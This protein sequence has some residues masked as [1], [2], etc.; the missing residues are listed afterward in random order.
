M[1][2]IVTKSAGFCFGVRKT[3]EIAVKESEKGEKIFTLGP[4]IHNPQVVAHLETKNIHPKESVSEINEDST[5]I[6]RTHGA[7]LDDMKQLEEMR[8]NLIDGT[9]PFVIR[10]QRMARRLSEQG[11]FV[12]IV[13]DEKHPEIKGVKSRAGKNS[14]VINPL[15]NN[16][17]IPEAKKIAVIAQTTLPEE[18]FNLIVEKLK[19]HAEELK[20]INTICRDTTIRQNE[21]KRIAKEVDVVL[22]VGGRNSANTNKLARISR[23]INPRTYHI[24]SP[25]EIKNEWFE[26][27]QTVGI[28]TGASTPEW[29][30][31]GVIKRIEGSISREIQD[32]FLHQ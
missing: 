19:P 20:V 2:I 27:A 22:V 26:N 10:S 24:E 1:K 14:I 28:T 6:I 23:E 29:I 25:E 16:S 18:D 15:N 21:A 30:I 31:E 17:V 3:V 32:T 9:C 5:V 11:Y 13:G 8:V 4:I 12:V 7:T